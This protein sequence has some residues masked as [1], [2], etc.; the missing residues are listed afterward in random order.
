VETLSG[1]SVVGPE[2]FRTG[3]SGTLS[4]RVK[5]YTLLGKRSRSSDTGIS[6]K[7]IDRFIE[8]VNDLQVRYG[9]IMELIEKDPQM[10]KYFEERIGKIES[11]K[12][13]I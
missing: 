7:D 5:M 12:P 6:E 11:K 3:A 4:S 2:V 13:K 9:N 10:K 8:S 1:R